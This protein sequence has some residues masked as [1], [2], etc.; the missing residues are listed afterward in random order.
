M[1]R[2]DREKLENIQALR[3]AAA[4]MVVLLH[5][6]RP[7][8]DAVGSERFLEFA[9]SGVDIF[10]VISGFIMMYTTKD[11][12]RTPVQ[13]WADRIRRIVPMYWIATLGMVALFVVG[14]HPAGIHALSL[15][16]V[17]ASMFFIPN[18]RADGVALPVQSLGWTLN[19]EMI[20]Y[21]TFG[22]ALAFRS[23]VKALACMAGLYLAMSA[24]GLIFQ[25][26]HIIAKYYTNTVVIEF[27]FGCGLGFLFVHAP[28]AF[29]FR[30]A[31]VVGAA[32]IAAGAIAL[33]ASEAFGYYTSP[34]EMSRFLVLGI[35]AAAIVYGALMLERAGLAASSPFVQLQ[36]RA[37]YAIYL[38]HMFL[39][40]P[41]H[42][43]FG[44][45]VPG[46]GVVS[47]IVIVGLTVVVAGVFGNLV[48]LAIETPLARLLSGK[49]SVRA[50]LAALVRLPGSLVRRLI[51]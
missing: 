48:H 27:L 24:I 35:P 43:I 33:P 46:D 10:F 28:K 51:A 6:C 26:Q 37:S 22:A 23:Q 42:A 14:F 20:F 29:A 25:P 4:Y 36:G 9:A 41:L 32:L 18:V 19:Y 50:E 39:L 17:L 34:F 21:V 16:D 44:R 11:F 8:R 45:L 15:K 2:T 38:F 31:R 7:L 13:F 5:A 12:R 49:S 3:C 30:G 40:Q 1:S 47:A